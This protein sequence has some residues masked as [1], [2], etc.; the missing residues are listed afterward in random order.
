[1][2]NRIGLFKIGRDFCVN[3]SFKRHNIDGSTYMLGHNKKKLDISGCCDL[4]SRH[5]D[6]RRRHW[7]ANFFISSLLPCILR[8]RMNCHECPTFNLTK[9]EHMLIK[10]CLS[11]YD[12]D[13]VHLAFYLIF[14]VLDT[15]PR[16]LSKNFWVLNFKNTCF[17]IFKNI[18]WLK[19]L[20]FKLDLCT[21]PTW[22]IP[23]NSSRRKMGD[24]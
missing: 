22:T 10:V 24:N 14:T 3:G 23:Q 17:L 5:T 13:P 18:C 4:G 8:D 11:Q 1:M 21:L 9:Q 19:T 15:P 2:A 20:I 16:F 6:P 7:G 12:I